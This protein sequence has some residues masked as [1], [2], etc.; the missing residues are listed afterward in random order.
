[1]YYLIFLLSP[2]L[3]KFRINKDEKSI[4][5]CS[6]FKIKFFYANFSFTLIGFIIHQKSL[7]IKLLQ[8]LDHVGQLKATP[9]V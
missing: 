4:I 9:A 7:P 1:M 6:L 5:Y 3:K 2:S 8:F